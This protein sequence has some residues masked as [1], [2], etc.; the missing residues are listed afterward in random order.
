MNQRIV[1]IACLIVSVAIGAHAQAQPRGG[2]RWL[3]EFDAQALAGAP[4]MQPP[5]L[6]NFGAVDLGGGGTRVGNGD[7]PAI[8]TTL[9]ANYYNPSFVGYRS[10]GHAGYASYAGQ[11]YGGFPLGWTNYPPYLNRSRFMYPYRYYPMRTGFS[12][13]NPRFYYGNSFYGRYASPYWSGFGGFGFPYHFG[14]FGAGGAGYTFG[15]FGYPYRYGVFGYPYPGLFSQPFSYLPSTAYFMYPGLG[16]LYI[17]PGF[18]TF[19][20]FRGY[21]GYGMPLMAPNYAG[22]FYW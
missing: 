3:S 1:A 15:G 7:Q 13:Y 4:V 11:G 21:G 9:Y 18:T 20:G 22:A 10:Y 12:V 2:A 6:R 5:V 16:G 14:A 8:D 19:P 17:P